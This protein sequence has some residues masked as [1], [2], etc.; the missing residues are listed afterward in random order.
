MIS[1]M[2]I[3]LVLITGG[4]EG[5]VHHTHTHTHTLAAQRAK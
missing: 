2:A 5:Q 4:T 1:G 3:E